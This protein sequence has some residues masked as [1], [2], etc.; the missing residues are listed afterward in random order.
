MK[1][2]A[3]DKKI[4]WID[5][6][7]SIGILIVVLCHVPQH[8]T[9]ERAFLCSFQMPL[10]FF[11]SGYLHKV[12][13]NS[14]KDTLKKYWTTLIVP[15]LL[16][17][18]IFYPY[19]LIVQIVDGH[20]L[21]LY[22]TII[23]PIINTFIG[24]PINGVT[25]FIVAIL[26]I[27]LYAN[28]ILSLQKKWFWTILSCFIIGVI[29]YMMYM[30][31]DSLKISFAIDS[32]LHFFAFFFIG[33]YFKIAQKMEI[34]V[35]NKSKLYF[36]LVFSATVT[37]IGIPR[38]GSSFFTSELL[39]YILGFFGSMT[40]LCICIMLNKF[41]SSIIRT[42]SSGTIVIFG[43]HWMFIGTINFIIKK[44]LGITGEIFYST[45]IAI[46][47]AAFIVFINYFII[48]FCK[49]HFQ[50]LLGYRK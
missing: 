44:Y 48:L 13:L 36:L 8:A 21:N 38:I 32:M 22:T 5:W 40:T 50:A 9:F 45:P 42:I 43:L 30:G 11:L 12:P 18:I 4:V 17:Q 29:R 49:K 39:H 31:N 26:I 46:G 19:W 33:Y 2:M 16:F 23:E 25:W 37:L 35:N 14:F 1:K 24:I 20:E 28:F 34:L 27:K 41:K 3:S 7:K 15:Y 10:F 47:V 6:A